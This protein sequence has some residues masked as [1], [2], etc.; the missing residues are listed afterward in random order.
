[1][2]LDNITVTKN[3]ITSV[4]YNSTSTVS[5]SVTRNITTQK[6][7]PPTTAP[8]PKKLMLLRIQGRLGNQMFQYAAA[9]GIARKNGFAFNYTGEKTLLPECFNIASPMRKEDVQNFDKGPDKAQWIDV[10]WPCCTYIPSLHFFP[11]YKKYNFV[12]FTQSWKYF[13]DFKDEIKATYKFKASIT[14]AAEK[15]LADRK[16]EKANGK[17]LVTVGIHIRRGDVANQP[18]YFGI[19][20]TVATK[21][22]IDNAMNYYRRKYKNVLFLVCS[23]GIDWFKKTIGGN[24]VVYSEGNNANVDMAILAESDHVIISTGSYSWWAGYL[25]KGEVVVY[26]HWPRPGSWLWS[27][28]KP[29]DFFYPSWIQME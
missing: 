11:F 24:D 25:A 16:R 20:Y 22:Y 23:N 12:G 21:S 9:L 10:R 1:M 28:F 15:F 13:E 26:K 8:G 4:T 17:P 14:S 29:E 2:S 6:T 19:G 3:N 27:M 5:V 7:I 18:E